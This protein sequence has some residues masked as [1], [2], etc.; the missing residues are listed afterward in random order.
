MLGILRHG[1]RVRSVRSL[2]ILKCSECLSHTNK[3]TENAALSILAENVLHGG[4]HEPL[5]PTYQWARGQV[6]SL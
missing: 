1:Y 5:R 2:L 4:S 6:G 3:G